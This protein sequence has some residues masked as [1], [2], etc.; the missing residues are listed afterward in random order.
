MK[1]SYPQTKKLTNRSTVYDIEHACGQCLNCRITRRAQVAGRLFLESLMFKN[2]SAFVTLTYAKENRPPGGSLCKHDLKIFRQRLKRKAEKLCLPLKMVKMGEYGEKAD[3]HPHYHLAIYGIPLDIAYAERKKADKAKYQ[4]ICRR[5]HHIP[6]DFPGYERLILEAWDYKGIVN[7]GIMEVH[8]AQYIAG[9]V[10]KKYLQ[11]QENPPGTLKEF[12]TWDK[13]NA[14]GRD[15]AMYI[16]ETL[17]AHKCYPMRHPNLAQG[18]DWKAVNW[19]NIVQVGMKPIYL[20]R[21]MKAKVLEFMG[22]DRTPEDTKRIRNYMRSVVLRNKPKFEAIRRNKPLI[23]I[24]LSEDEKKQ[25]RINR[26]KA[27]Q[28]RK[29]KRL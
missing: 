14:V 20:D 29:R 10:T 12:V 11:T 8:S 23:E 9:Y 21:Y 1:C 24:V 13:K 6:V 15:A 22:G 19:E 28:R 18:D 2:A 7:I 27:M 4:F 3:R 17:K 26:F 5:R 16:A 25:Q